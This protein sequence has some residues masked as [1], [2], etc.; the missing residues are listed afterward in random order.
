MFLW[1][2]AITIRPFRKESIPMVLSSI[3]GDL[4]CFRELK[5]NL[6]W[7]ENRELCRFAATSRFYMWHL[8]SLARAPGEFTTV[9]LFHVKNMYGQMS[10]WWPASRS[11]WLKWMLTLVIKL[12]CCFNLQTN[13]M[14]S[15]LGNWTRTED[16]RN[17]IDAH[18]CSVISWFVMDK[19]KNLGFSSLMISGGLQQFSQRLATAFDSVYIPKNCR[20]LRDL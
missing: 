9:H 7:S 6:W 14:G 16:C 20:A 5:Q 19:K 13:S 11:A 1:C 4:L 17:N 18:S 12:C 3:V 10:M 15:T 2:A 8:S